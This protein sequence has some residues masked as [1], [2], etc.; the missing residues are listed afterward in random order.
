[1]KV[2][3]DVKV[4]TRAIKH[5]APLRQQLA[6]KPHDARQGE[7][8]RHAKTIRR[9]PPVTRPRAGRSKAGE[10]GHGF[11]LMDWPN[12]PTFA[13]KRHV[14]MLSQYAERFAKKPIKPAFSKIKTVLIT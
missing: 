6:S 12:L 2:K 10:H 13:D 7:I 11:S 1:V 4:D 14:K 9:A 5:P 8:T 3:V